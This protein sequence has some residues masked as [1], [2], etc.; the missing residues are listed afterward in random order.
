MS[1][2]S[3]LPLLLL[4]SGACAVRTP[5]PVAPLPVTRLSTTPGAAGDSL[6]QFFDSLATAPGAVARPGTLSLDTDGAPAVAWAELLQ[7]SVLMGLV[8]EAM[9]NNR[10]LA[11]ARARILEFRAELGVDNAARLPEVTLAGSAARQQVVFGSLGT[12]GFDAFVATA[13]LSWELD[14]WGRIRGNVAGARADLEGRREDVRATVL[15]LVGDVSSAYL[16]LRALDQN[17]AIAE[18]TLASRRQTLRLAER[19]FAEGVISEL[20]VRQFE[21]Q[22]AGPAARVAEF[23]LA[24]AQTEHQLSQL[25]GR[26][27]G[28]IDRGRPLA[29]VA[30]AVVLPDSVSSILVAQRPDI[31]RASHDL[32]AAAARAGSARAARLPSFLLTGQYGS[33][34]E[35]PA[36]L[37]KGT[38]EIYTIQAGV[39][40]PLFDN[41]RRAN[42]ARAESAREEQARFRYEQAVLT[43]LR[44][45]SDALLA[46]RATHEQLLAQDVQVRALRRAYDLAVRRYDSGVSSYLEVLDAQ[47]SLFEAEL[48][49]TGVEQAYLTSG[50]QLFRALGGSWQEK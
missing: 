38:T 12:F 17:L 7:D 2:P 30:R 41:G 22:V 44:E 40:I 43:A 27:P 21:A 19:R 25:L 31:L 50:V 11:I 8:R 48:A 29:E 10:D 28:P 16:R 23:Q 46:V 33:Q 15:S 14:F 47:R 9:T 6:R 45:V 49:T 3:I 18:R 4:L 32:E 1:R 26:A 37:F 24:I 13:N 42:A 39:A 36:D 35:S 5:P 20:D 34:A